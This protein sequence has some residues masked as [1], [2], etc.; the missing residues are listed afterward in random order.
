MNCNVHNFLLKNNLKMYVNEG[1]STLSFST[2]IK[3]IN[4]FLKKYYDS[5]TVLLACLPENMTPWG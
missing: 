5:Q 4:G 3:S 2:S 1:Y